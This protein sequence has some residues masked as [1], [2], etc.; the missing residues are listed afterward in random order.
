MNIYQDMDKGAVLILAPHHWYKSTE[1]NDMQI[2]ECDV[3][4]F[5]NIF[6]QYASKF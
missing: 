4:S 5:Q 6:F 1:Q 3:K 2:L